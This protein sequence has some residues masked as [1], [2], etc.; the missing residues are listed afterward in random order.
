MNKLKYYIDRLIE[1]DKGAM[2]RTISDISK[3]TGKNKIFLFFDIIWCGLVHGAGYS[4]YNLFEMYNLN[5]K[6]R[7]TYLTRAR[8]N[9]LI[10]K[11]N[12]VEYFKYLEDKDLFNEKFDKF[13]KRDWIKVT[14]DNEKEVYSWIVNHLNFMAKPIDGGCGK[15]I[16]KYI[17]KETEKLSISEIKEKIKKWNEGSKG[18]ILEE[19]V[20][21]NDEVSKIYPLSV[22][23]VRMVTIIKNGVPYLVRSYF[24]IGNN[25]NF[26]DNFNSGGMTVEVD[27]VKGIVKDK[28][29]DK[30]KNLYDNHPYTGEKIKGFKFPFWEEAVKMVKEMALIVPEMGY[31]GWDIAFTPDGPVVIEGNEYP[32][33]DIY[34]LPEHTPNKE[35]VYLDFLYPEKMKN[36]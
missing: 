5:E 34:Q 4:D 35:G 17:E 12:K 15:G 28:A 16:E 32:G 21:Q 22:N 2:F 20:T 10:K 26:V 33:H 6:Q 7:K 13:L 19:L 11:Y 31:V 36:N 8:N 27:R 9:G 18:F 14:N 23:T 1:M 29:I 3:K 25:G 30:N 24:R